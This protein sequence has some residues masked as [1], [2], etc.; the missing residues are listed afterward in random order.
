MVF[1][2]HVVFTALAALFVTPLLVLW[3]ISLCLA[4]RKNDP[5]RVAVAWIKATAE[6]TRSSH[7]CLV[8]S[9]FF[10][11][12][13]GA[14]NIWSTSPDYY[15]SSWDEV[16]VQLSASHVNST[17]A[18][19]ANLAQICLFITFIELA[20]GFMLC[21]KGDAQAA[22][23]RRFARIAIS[24]WGFVLFALAVSHFGLYTSAGVRLRGILSGDYYSTRG[25]QDA[26]NESVR[27][28]NRLVLA[29]LILKWLTSIVMLSAASVVVHRVRNNEMLRKTSVLFLVAT[30]LDFIRLLVVMAINI[31]LSLMTR[32]RRSLE[33]E[34][35]GYIVSPFFDFVFMFVLLVLLFTLAIRKRKGLW[36]QPQQE[37]NYP[38]VMYV[39]AMPGQP[40]PAGAMPVQQ[41]GMPAYL[42][43]AQQQQQHMM[44][45]QQPQQQQVY[46]YYPQH[47]Q[48]P[49]P[50]FQQPEVQ[51]QQQP[52]QE[53]KPNV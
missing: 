22:P 53:P 42:Q 8:R 44:Q 32:T 48:Q 7:L 21:L 35:V 12:V 33:I 43:V 52:A 5:A 6:A 47:M 27:A 50:V 31:H 38:T 20:N 41:Q 36:S 13:S 49:A 39:P 14:L 9:L 16:D 1:V 23:S 45:Q 19:L 18:F 17:G 26:H 30:I 37:W 2:G 3:F 51:Q 15:Y 11:T 28:I 24:V 4:R 46:A 10:Y 25:D 40:M 29:T 34:I